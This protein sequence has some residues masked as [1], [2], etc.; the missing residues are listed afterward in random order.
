MSRI[1]QHIGPYKGIRI[2]S[3]RNGSVVVTHNV[4]F[5]PALSLTPGPILQNLTA[6]LVAE[7][8]RTQA[9]QGDCQE[10]NT[11]LC[12][13]LPPN[14]IVR[15]MTVLAS[16]EELCLQMAP[17]GYG[18][19]YAPIVTLGGTLSCLSRCSPR[20][21][22]ALNCHRG[23]CR[24]MS[25]GPTCFCPDPY[26]YWY[27]GETCAT[28]I[29]KLGLGLG[30]PL[31]LM[32][33][34]AVVSI[35]LLLRARWSQGRA[36]KALWHEK[37]LFE[38]DGD[39]TR[40]LGSALHQGSSNGDSTRSGSFHPSLEAVDPSVPSLT[41]TVS[42]TPSPNVNLLMGLWQFKSGYQ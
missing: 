21:P 16:P 33:L 15:N 35:A 28:R 24:L 22:D 11:T 3:L 36:G 1:Y 8:N 42:S 4:T 32:A 2:I 26:D 14:P 6:Q 17:P 10:N 7:L 23:Q 39:W 19:H 13:S 9:S 5:A 30:L 25:A 29:S 38:E 12:L 41:R 34:V 31:A 20:A 40:P 18:V 37:S 27:P